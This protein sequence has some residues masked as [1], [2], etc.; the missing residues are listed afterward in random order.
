MKA[1]LPG[2]P[3]LPRREGRPR[4]PGCGPEC[5]GPGRPKPQN[6][7][8]FWG[9]DRASVSGPGL[10]G[11]IHERARAQLGAA[12][13]QA[14]PRTALPRARRLRR[15]DSCPV[16]SHTQ[17]RLIP[18]SVLRS[19]CC[20][21]TSPPQTQWLNAAGGLSDLPRGRKSKAGVIGR[22]SGV[23]RAGSLSG[24][25][26]SARALLCLSLEAARSRPA[27]HPA[28]SQLFCSWPSRLPP[29]RTPVIAMGL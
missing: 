28:L 25:R 29:I 2:L 13:E 18:A 5:R 23:G 20:C 19:H 17:G 10:R 6:H 7:T 4:C 11:C 27:G 9:T 1:A 12:E 24:L 16:C 22:R 3:G 26:R 15:A 8:P 14:R 21:N